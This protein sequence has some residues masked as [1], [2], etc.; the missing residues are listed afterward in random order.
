VSL[1]V[2]RGQPFAMTEASP[3]PRT[4]STPC[5]WRR[6]LASADIGDSIFWITREDPLSFSGVQRTTDQ[7]LSAF[8]TQL[9]PK[10]TSVLKEDH[11]YEHD[12][13]PCA[14]AHLRIIRPAS[15]HRRGRQDL[16]TWNYLDVRDT[17]VLKGSDP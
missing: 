11:E 17:G 13:A 14:R 10:P 2:R 1:A 12:E 15:A 5:G 3:E 7:W 6:G 9:L 8:G 16:E 4:M